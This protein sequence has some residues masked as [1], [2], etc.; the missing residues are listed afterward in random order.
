MEAK[1]EA[2]PVKL[3]IFCSNAGPH[4][5]R[6]PPGP[7]GAP[8]SIKPLESGDT[9]AFKLS[10]VCSREPTWYPRFTFLGTSKDFKATLVNLGNPVSL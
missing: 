10:D 8:V 3:L 2:F 5:P 6:G 1:G 4:G 7:A 9:D